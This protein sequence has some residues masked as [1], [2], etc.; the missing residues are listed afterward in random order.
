MTSW[1]ISRAPSSLI[2]L[3]WNGQND[4]QFDTEIRVKPCKFRLFVQNCFNID[5]KSRWDLIEFSK[6][7]SMEKQ[8][9][10]ANLCFQHPQR[11]SSQAWTASI[12]PAT[13]LEISFQRFS[14]EGSYCS[15]DTISWELVYFN[16]S[17]YHFGK[18][19]YQTGSSMR[20]KELVCIETI[21][22]RCR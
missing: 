21:E 1:R 20:H 5:E 22:I 12:P 7:G 19:S 4:G 17:Y 6:A 11:T 10:N 15:D 14:S 16:A 8:R 2:S 9:E 13:I 18:E 3:S